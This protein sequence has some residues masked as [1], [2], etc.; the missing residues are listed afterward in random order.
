MPVRLTPA[1]IR[2]ALLNS[3]SEMERNAGDFVNA[4][5]IDFT[6]K[7]ICTFQNTILSIMT[8]E[9]HSLKRELFEY[10][11]PLGRNPPTRSAFIQSRKKLNSTAFPYLLDSFNRKIPFRKTFKGV[12]M[13][14]CDGTDSNIP[15]EKKDT[16]SLIPFNS[17]KGGY[18]QNHTVVMYDLLEKR[19]VDAVIQPRREMCEVDA[20]CEMIDRCPV[21]GLCCFIAD[22]GFMSFNLMA[23]AAEN[24]Q[25]YLIRVKD[26][27]QA[28][29]PFKYIPLPD[30][31]G[32][33]HAEFVLSRKHSQL[34][35]VQP[36]K[37][38]WLHTQRQF[39]FIAL[40]DKISTYTLSFR[41]VKVELSKDTYEYL[42]TNLPEEDFPISEIK[43]LYHLRWG[44]EVSFFF[45]KYGIAMN[46]F[47]SI[48]RD[49]I[50]Q[51]IFAKLI[52]Y[53]FI[54]LIVSCVKVPDRETKYTY[55]VSFSDAIYKCR[56]FLLT[57]MK[58]SRLLELLLRDLTP[59][60][61]GRSRERNM[62]SQCLKSLQNRT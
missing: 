16:A 35:K 43:A 6:R 18:Y 25:Y 31:E 45:L 20:C 27:D 48:R 38:K 56:K 30:G 9:T 46:Y 21:P 34:Q 51:E 5:G 32:Q 33:T 3:I 60:R 44:I 40:G 39:D 12:H 10:Y 14:G 47:H 49:F 23:H 17:Q 7:R 11:S 4:P 52:L 58:S 24:G 2:N 8:M 54:A 29:S 28:N 15:A 50:R 55:Q 19:Y 53:N 22:R 61:P 42:I 13:I 59:L 26:V 41:L 37:Y 1:H 36:G 62:K 57:T